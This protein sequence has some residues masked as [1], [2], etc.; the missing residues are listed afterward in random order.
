MTFEPS[1]RRISLLPLTQQESTEQILAEL[2]QKPFLLESEPSSEV[3]DASAFGVD[4]AFST[5]IFPIL[6]ILFGGRAPLRPKPC[7]VAHLVLK[8]RN[9]LL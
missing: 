4:M 5:L 7:L 2:N 3:K 1:A 9:L 6:S 8:A